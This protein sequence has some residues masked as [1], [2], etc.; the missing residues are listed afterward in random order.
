MPATPVLSWMVVAAANDLVPRLR[1][2][3]GV[4][5]G[6]A[7]D[8]LVVI[9]H[10]RAE[11]VGH[12]EDL[13]AAAAD[14]EKLWKIIVEERGLAGV[15]IDRH[16]GGVARHEVDVAA[17]D[18]CNVHRSARGQRGLHIRRD[19]LIRLEDIDDLDVGVLRLEP[20][21]DLLQR[22]VP[23]IRLVVVDHD[24]RSLGARRAHGN[25]RESDDGEKQMADAHDRT[26]CRA[27]QQ[28]DPRLQSRGAAHRA[29]WGRT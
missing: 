26:S 19:G 29:H 28:R 13:V 5:A 24:L 3:F 8:V 15:L 22:V 14:I 18:C 4:E 16:C 1:R 20:P 25:D 27:K 23:F 12:R 2:R 7:E 10:R 6:F 11:R 21:E 9:E 17:G